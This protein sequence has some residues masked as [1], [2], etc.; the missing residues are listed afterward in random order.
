MFLEPV[1]SKTP[2]ECGGS[3]QCCS[4]QPKGEEGAEPGSYPAAIEDDEE[5]EIDDQRDC[6]H[7]DIASLESF[8]FDGAADG[9]EGGIDTRCHIPIV[10]KFEK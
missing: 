5:Q 6:C 2:A 10:F 3:P 4:P 7:H 1:G 8:K 9:R